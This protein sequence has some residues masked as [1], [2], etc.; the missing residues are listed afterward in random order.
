MKNGWRLAT[1]GLKM[2]VQ[3][4]GIS[5]EQEASVRCY[6]FRN[7]LSGGCVVKWLPFTR[8]DSGSEPKAPAFLA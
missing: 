7:D 8:G 4:A 6:L 1:T 3:L 5:F 2:Q